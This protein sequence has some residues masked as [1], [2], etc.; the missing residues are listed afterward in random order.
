LR[1]RYT[2]I[3]IVGKIGPSAKQAIPL[4]EKNVQEQDP[5]LQTASVW[6]LVQIDPQPAGRAAQCLEPLTRGLAVPDLRVRLE[7]IQALGQLGPA[8]KPVRKALE[9]IA[10][11][12]DEVVRKAAVDALFKIGN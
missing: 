5:F 6:T 1:E 2:A 4:L 12:P 8:A 11:D 9:G 3:F 7:V 10:N